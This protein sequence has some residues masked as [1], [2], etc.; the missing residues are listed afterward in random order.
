MTHDER[1]DGRVHAVARCVSCGWEYAAWY[2]RSQLREVG[3]GFWKCGPCGGVLTVARVGVPG[4]P[5]PAGALAGSILTGGRLR[6]AQLSL[7]L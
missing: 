3:A 7:G 1:A 2:L 4:A 6:P 5:S